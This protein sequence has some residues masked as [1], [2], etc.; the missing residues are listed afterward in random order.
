MFD[1]LAVKY[2]YQLSAP[3]AV[4]GFTVGATHG[5]SI[6]NW[7]DS[8]PL[9]DGL[10]LTLGPTSAAWLLGNCT[11]MDSVPD[12]L[13]HGAGIPIS[14]A[15]TNLNAAYTNYATYIDA[16]ARSC[17]PEGHY[18]SGAFATFT[19]TVSYTPSAV[20]PQKTSIFT[21]GPLTFPLVP[22]QH[23][24][25]IQM[26]RLGEFHAMR[27]LAAPGFERSALS[28]TISNESRRH[29]RHDA[30]GI[31]GA[32]PA[33]PPG[34]GWITF[35]YVDIWLSDTHI[36][37][38]IPVEYIITTT[39]PLEGGIGWLAAN[40]ITIPGGQRISHT[41]TGAISNAPSADGNR[42]GFWPLLL[43]QPP[44]RCG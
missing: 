26:L 11:A 18:D 4:D 14:Q 13:K 35:P 6:Y 28:V 27:L 22:H 39:P 10:E 8:N 5:A 41:M 12:V 31:L 29:V 25:T 32:P 21:M 23:Y 20:N 37:P 19:V 2:R 1:D 34:K 15:V 40:N 3:F 33:S 43:H 17:V 42:L 38:G 16:L 24:S 44:P 7:L 36:M 30:D 9:V